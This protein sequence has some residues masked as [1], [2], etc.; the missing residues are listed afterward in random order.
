[1]AIRDAR[2]RALSTLQGVFAS[3]GT[4][5][6]EAVAEAYDYQRQLAAR[7]PGRISAVVVLTDGED[8]DSTMKLP[9]LL[10][11]V[12]SGGETQGIPVFTI[13]YGR[14]ANR[15]VLEQ[16]ATATGARFYVGTPANIRSVF[17]EISTFF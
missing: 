6:Y 8:T 16:I 15:Q 3:G 4:A 13:G 5:L 7:D 2:A 9:E 1:M 12:R 14:D 10:A 11:R 17:R